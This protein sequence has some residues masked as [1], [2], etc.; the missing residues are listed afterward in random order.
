MKEK[1][2]Q[3]K[4]VQVMQDWK[5][6]HPCA[7]CKIQYKYYQMEFDHLGKKTCTLGKRKAPP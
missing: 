6:C 5:G 7:D 4:A 3:R 2:T 1:W